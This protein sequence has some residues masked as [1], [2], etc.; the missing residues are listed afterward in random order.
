MKT[1]FAV[2]ILTVCCSV[3]S[4]Q[5]KPTIEALG[6]IAGCW[7]RSSATRTSQE[8]WMKPAGGTMMGMS[9][10]VS[11]GK[12]VAF[13]H[14]MLKQNGDNI[15]YIATPSGQTQT[16]FRLVRFSATEAVFENPEHD[17]PTRIM[18]RLK[19][20]GSL[21]ARIEGNMNGQERGIDFPFN[22]VSCDK[23]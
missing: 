3:P 20:D 2:I 22:K 7:E 18:Y 11:N 19:E 21:H 12:T 14:L 15:D 17:F 9:R 1:Q 23:Q 10:T 13:E 16:A 8:Q 4:A 6:W 5:E